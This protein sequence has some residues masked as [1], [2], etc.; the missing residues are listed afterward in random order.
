MSGKTVMAAAAMLLGSVELAS[1]QPIVFPQY[2]YW[3]GGGFYSPLTGTGV[4][5][6]PPYNVGLAPPPNNAGAKPLYNYAPGR[7]LRSHRNW[8][9]SGSGHNW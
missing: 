1:A 8:R 9:D 2:S 7:H 6:E 3:Y 5:L 4:G